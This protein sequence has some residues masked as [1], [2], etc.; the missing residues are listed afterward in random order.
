MTVLK[1]LLTMLSPC[2]LA[3]G[4]IDH[5][6][7]VPKL[8]QVDRAMIQ[9]SCPAES[10]PCSYVWLV[11]Q[12]TSIDFRHYTWCDHLWIGSSY[13]ALSPWSPLYAIAHY[14]IW[15]ALV[16]FVEWP[17][18]IHLLYLNRVLIDQKQLMWIHQLEFSNNL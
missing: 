18:C 1:V 4:W 3:Q 11:V 10:F 5:P 2:W 14:I 12:L 9:P 13:F 17:R 6:V 15:M 8:L 7:I 16:I